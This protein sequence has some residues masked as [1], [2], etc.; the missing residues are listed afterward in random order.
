[1]LQLKTLRPGFKSN[2][3]LRRTQQ[4]PPHIVRIL[5]TRSG[6]R[7]LLS[8]K[9]AKVDFTPIGPCRVL[10]WAALPENRT[11]ATECLNTPSIPPPQLPVVDKAAT[12]S[13]GIL[14]WED[15]W[16]YRKWNFPEALKNGT[17][18]EYGHALASHIMTAPMTIYSMLDPLLEASSKVITSTREVA[19]IYKNNKEKTATMKVRWCIIGARSEASL[20]IQYWQEMLDMIHAERLLAFRKY[21]I[22]VRQSGAD[23]SYSRKIPLVPKLL[24]I[25]L[26]FIGPEMN[27]QSSIVLHP[28]KSLR[29]DEYDFVGDDTTTNIFTSCTMQWR[30]KGL[31]HTHYNEINNQEDVYDKQYDAY[32]LFNP[33]IGH[34]YLQKLWR[35]TLQL[36]FEQY[37]RISN[38][39]NGGCTVVLTSHSMKDALRDSKLLQH[40]MLFA[41][42]YMEDPTTTA[43]ET[44][45]VENESP[46]Q[47]PDEDEIKNYYTENPFAS[48]IYYHDPMVPEQSKPSHI[49][50]PNHYVALLRRR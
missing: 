19:N 31:Y 16:S 18:R 49:V 45:K 12:A 38:S 13:N 39:L 8:T 24:E 48:R 50:R 7:R 9:T 11:V 20:P 17:E 33:G 25:T 22:E 28:S 35:P 32:I 4:R 5:V 21:T 47:C 27:L 36:I 44:D 15:Y 14:N 3:A 26:D 34:P 6:S 43:T 46:E 41:E 40:Y 30:Y 10:E 42:G 37:Y 29:P 23:R 1:M 2:I